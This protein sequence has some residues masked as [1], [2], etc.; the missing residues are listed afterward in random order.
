MT[1]RDAMETVAEQVLREQ[2]PLHE[3]DQYMAAV[4][5]FVEFKVFV[6]RFDRNEFRSITMWSTDIAEAAA[7]SLSSFE[8]D[9]W[10]VTNVI[11]VSGNPY[12]KEETGGDSRTIET[13]EMTSLRKL[14]SPLGR[15]LWPVVHASARH[16]SRF[17]DWLYS[18]A[19]RL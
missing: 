18:A 7:Q 12:M 10:L 3:V 6:H 2:L 15:A 4:R 16:T 13:M 5:D 14:L 11:R 17:S 1:E 8:G 9:G 19:S